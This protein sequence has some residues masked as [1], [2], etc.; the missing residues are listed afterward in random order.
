MN[1]ATEAHVKSAHGLTFSGAAGATGNISIRLMEAAVTSYQGFFLPPPGR[2][3]SV[4]LDG[5]IISFDRWGRHLI[6][7]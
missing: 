1:H 2:K 5:G 3:C 4:F 7:G 6:D